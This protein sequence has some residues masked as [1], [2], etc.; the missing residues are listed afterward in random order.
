LKHREK[1]LNI[2]PNIAEIFVRQLNFFSGLLTFFTGRGSSGYGKLY[3]GFLDGKKAVGH[4]Y[5]LPAG[6]PR[7]L[8]S[9]S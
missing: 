7:T 6:R 3:Q 9:L 5:A 1:Y 4:W 8:Y 2:L